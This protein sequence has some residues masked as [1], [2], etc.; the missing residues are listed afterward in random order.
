MQ[1]TFF[2]SFTR[3]TILLSS[4]FL[5]LYI[6]I[7]FHSPFPGLLYMKMPWWRWEKAAHLHA[8]GMPDKAAHRYCRSLHSASRSPTI[9][10]I[11]FHLQT[12]H[13]FTCGASCHATCSCHSSYTLTH[14]N[15]RLKLRHICLSRLHPGC[16]CNHSRRPTP[17]NL[18]GECLRSNCL[19]AFTLRQRATAI[20]VNQF[21]LATS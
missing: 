15:R 21:A 14:E 17:R 18:Y 9:S 2:F 4:L 10:S 20:H 1:G 3:T 19:W 16:T 5:S 12:S 13:I 7:I 6:Y 11:P 8:C